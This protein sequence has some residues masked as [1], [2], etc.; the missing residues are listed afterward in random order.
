MKKFISTFILLVVFVSSSFAAETVPGDVLVIFKNPSENEV[1]TASLASEGEHSAYVA[2]V[3]SE[4]DAEVSLAY[5]TLS[6]NNNEMFV[7]LHSDTKS[8]QELLEELLARPDVKGAQ[9][10]YLKYPAAT[11]NDT[12]Y[13]KLWGMEA[14]NAPKVWDKTKGSNSVYVAVIDTGI[15]TTHEDLKDNIAKDYCT[16]YFKASDGNHYYSHDEAYYQDDTSEPHG[17]H[18]AGIIGA[19]GNNNIGV[20]GVNWNTKIIAYKVNDPNS[21]NPE[22]YQDAYI[23]A[24]L[25]NILELVNSG[26]NIAAV[27]MSFGGWSSYTP[28]AVSSTNDLLWSAMKNASDAG[29]IICVAA[30][31]ESQAVGV[32]APCDDP[33]GRYDD[34]GTWSGSYKKDDY[35]YP[36]SYLNLDNMIVVAAASQDV[37]GKIIRSAEAPEGGYESDSNYS[38]KYVHIA[39]PGSHIVSTVKPGYKIVDIELVEDGVNNYASW[40]GTSMAAPYVAGT[41]ALLKSA[42][43]DATGSQIKRAILEGANKNYCTNDANEVT[44]ADPSLHTI[45]NTSK[46][47]FLDVDGAYNLLA[48]IIEEDAKNSGGGSGGCISNELGIRNVLIL[49]AFILLSFGIMKFKNV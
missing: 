7:L 33:A 4:M 6:E 8:E 29:L 13:S 24:A 41:A 42:Y 18:I 36:A 49:C 44:Y 39:A 2:S 17:T 48:E 10:N 22:A 34:N 19:V 35:V 20:A 46:Y 38:S 43:P 32:P 23:I 30:G 16:A 3:A 37:S 28:S 47:G 1:T 31:N 45:D 27:N 15:D 5:D 11:P 12:Y 21:N 14:I 25:N 40:A 26:V 9:L